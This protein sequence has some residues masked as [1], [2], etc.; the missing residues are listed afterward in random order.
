M[1][2]QTVQPPG[3]AIN[4]QPPSRGFSL[5]ELII[6]VAIIAILAAVAIPAFLN[7]RA[8]AVDSTTQQE[9]KNLADHVSSMALSGSNTSTWTGLGSASGNLTIDSVVTPKNGVLVYANSSNNAWCVSKQSS[10]TGQIYVAASNATTSGVYTATQHC[11]SA[12][13]TPSSG[14]LST[15]LVS[16]A[17]NLMTASAAEGSNAGN[18]QG[19]RTTVTSVTTPSMSDETALRITSN[20]TAG[21]GYAVQNGSY[22]TWVPVVAGRT[23]TV[24]SSIQPAAGNSNPSQIVY[25]VQMDWYSSAG[26]FI[27]YA[28]SS[29]GS[30]P[31]VG[32]WTDYRRTATAPAGAAYARVYPF[33]VAT[34]AVNGD[35]WYVDKIGL[36]E[37]STGQW[38][39]PGQPIYQ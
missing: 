31:P 1:N 19:S 16:S 24:S 32:T 15:T 25:G 11:S 4:T 29:P 35:S 38:A 14:S 33:V 2:N 8:K 5:I 13:S 18:W 10:G 36:W 17:G 22:T 30:A 3:E 39:P 34:G 26:A 20:G 9:V 37:G 12:A 27:S 7:Q 23:Y 21:N 6:T 28:Y